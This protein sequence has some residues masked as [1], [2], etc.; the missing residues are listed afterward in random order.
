M[1]C[2]PGRTR[3]NIRSNWVR[4]TTLVMEIV[5]SLGSPDPEYLRDRTTVTYVSLGATSLRMS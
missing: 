4:L 2:Q 3:H 1:P 5:P